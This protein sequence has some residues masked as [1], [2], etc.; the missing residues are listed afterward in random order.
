M[1]GSVIPDLVPSP[2][3]G[4]ADE[5]SVLGIPVP[6]GG[7]QLKQTPQD[8][9]AGPPG[10]TSLSSTVSLP[11]DSNK[12]ISLTVIALIAVVF[13]LDW[14]QSF[15]ISLLIG[16][17]LSYTL[18]PM[19]VWLH[20]KLK[21]P[22]LVGS[23]IVML[24]LIAGLCAAAYGL[25]GE[26][27]SII[28][29][30]PVAAKKISRGI[31]SMQ[32][33]RSNMQVMQKA[34][35]TVERATS[36]I[37]PSSSQG[38]M[39]VIVDSPPFR[40]G[41][42]LWAGSLGVFGFLAQAAMVIFLAYF[43]LLAGDTFKRKLVKLAGPTMAR[44][45]ITVQILDEINY[46]IQRYMFMLLITNTLVGL[47]SWGI[48]QWLGLQN[49]GAWAVAAGFLHV[50]PYFGTLLTAVITGLAA[51]IQFNSIAMAVIVAAAS[52]GIAVVV[53]VFITT[54]MIGRIANMNAAAVFISLLFWT[55]LWG[56]WGILLSVPIIV[57][58]KVVSQHV[59]QL[60][61]LAELLTE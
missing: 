57:I 52:I 61:P 39:H 23:T 28:D 45:K 44:R 43:L 60:H 51:F 25:R 56:V 1:S 3:P 27:Q 9:A 58:I 54:W 49:A 24:T 5:F 15:F 11:A 46:S 17:L 47:I 6:E 20:K 42:L 33:N 4:V 37:T 31:A 14:A 13:A 22:R 40:I 36:G 12:N 48:F 26:V 41:D 32:T 8:E 16:V 50:I 18:S 30:L 10:S 19:V 7:I 2:Q 21:L 55:W 34:A 53:G 38:T 35:N 59:E 29:E